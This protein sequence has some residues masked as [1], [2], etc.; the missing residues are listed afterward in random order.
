MPSSASAAIYIES[1]AGDAGIDSRSTDRQ[2]AS[3]ARQVAADRLPRAY[4]AAASSALAK[5]TAGSVDRVL[6][7]RRFISN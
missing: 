3:Y 6:A 4:S 2:S 1:V 7:G 5:A